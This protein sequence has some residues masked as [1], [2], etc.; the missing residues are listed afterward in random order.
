MHKLIIYTD[1][2][3]RGN[4]GPAA[5]GVVIYDFGG[6]ELKRISESVGETTNNQAEYKALIRALQEAIKMGFDK[7]ICHLDSELV[8]RQ[9]NGKYKIKEPGLKPLASQILALTQK[10]VQVEFVHVRREKNKLADQLV[11]EALDKAI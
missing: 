1:G 7:A 9:L 10:F 8:V 5:I 4:P 11:N 2:G 6:R 3:A